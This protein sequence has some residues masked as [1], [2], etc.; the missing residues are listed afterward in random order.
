MVSYLITGF[1]RFR[2]PVK[3]E[4][5]AE[6]LAAPKDAGDPAVEGTEAAADVPRNWIR[7][8]VRFNVL[9]FDTTYSVY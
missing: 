8:V 9:S 2:V 1:M 6:G 3:T 5:V 4:D 7:V